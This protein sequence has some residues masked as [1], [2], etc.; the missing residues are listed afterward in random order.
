MQRLDVF[1]FNKKYVKS[2]KQ[3][4]DLIKD[5]AVMVNEKIENKC[6]CLVDESVDIKII[7]KI[8]PY[9]SR[10]GYKLE[11]A[12]ENSNFDIKDK[13][14]LD[15]GASTGGFTDFCLQNGAKK[16]YCVDVGSNQLALKLRQNKNVICIENTDI[17]EIDAKNFG[18]VDIVV[19]DVSFISLTKISHKIAEI[20]KPNNFCIVLIKPQFEC[21]KDIAKKFKGIIKDEKIHKLVITKVVK[22]FSMQ[23]LVLQNIC[24]SKILGGDGNVE[25]VAKFVKKM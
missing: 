19:C 22:N 21:G 9:V 2:R 12:K 13:I 16:V 15:I 11:S 1:L 14:V 4:Q 18:D 3:A 23:N 20:L 7:K 17:R 10:A 5:N 24:K 25:Y 8:C 6:S